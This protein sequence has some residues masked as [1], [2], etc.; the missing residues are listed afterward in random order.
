MYLKI[1]SNFFCIIPKFKLRRLT[2]ETY[3]FNQ[4]LLRLKCLYLFNKKCMAFLFREWIEYNIHLKTV[5][6]IMRTY[7]FFAHMKIT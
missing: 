5:Y 7:F 4:N 6:R 2:N 3:F 1:F